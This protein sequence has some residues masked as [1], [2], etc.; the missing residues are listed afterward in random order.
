MIAGMLNLNSCL[1]SSMQIVFLLQKLSKLDVSATA[2]H[3]HFS[4]L[5]GWPKLSLSSSSGAM[6]GS[7][8]NACGLVEFLP[9]QNFVLKPEQPNFS[10]RQECCWVSFF[11]LMKGFVSQ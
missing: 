8:D 10:A 9:G 2:H 6:S 3:L 5:S 7:C 4:G 1:E 11:V